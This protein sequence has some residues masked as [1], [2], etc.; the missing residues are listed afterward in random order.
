M[1]VTR[2]L[3][4][5]KASNG[6]A[7]EPPPEGPHSGYLVIQDE[8]YEA[9][10]EMIGCCGM[11]KDQGLRNLLFPQNRLLT[12]DMVFKAFLVPV[13]GMPLSANRYYVIHPKG[14]MQG[15]SPA[16]IYQVFVS[17]LPFMLN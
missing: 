5:Y 8:A 2:P 17:Y 9:Q 12:A 4:L 7:S 1:Y 10:A 3:S 15:S 6:A 14:K 11:R 16:I 13:P